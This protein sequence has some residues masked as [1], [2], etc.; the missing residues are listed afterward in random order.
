MYKLGNII[1]HIIGKMA[2][3]LDTGVPI[4]FLK[5]DIKDGYWQI[6][7]NKKDVGNFAYVLPPEIESNAVELVITDLLCS[8]RNRNDT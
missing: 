2:V 7:L 5:I 1:P 3:A 8:H 4:L 6:V